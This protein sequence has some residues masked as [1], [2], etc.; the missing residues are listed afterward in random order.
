MFGTQLRLTSSHILMRIHKLQQCVHPTFCDLHIAVQQHIIV[1]VHLLQGTVISTGKA[2]I[3]VKHYGSNRRK[4][5]TEQ[6]QRIICR[7]IISNHYVCHLSR[8][9]YHR[10]QETAHHRCTVPVEYYYCYFLH[11]LSLFTLCVSLF[12]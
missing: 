10:R 11:L 8:M 3:L 1:I 2:I 6:R 5:I 7:S 4:L 9:L 12:T